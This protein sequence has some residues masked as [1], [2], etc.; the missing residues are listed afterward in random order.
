LYQ[1]TE[2]G[3]N[4]ELVKI[5][6][7]KQQGFLSRT[8]LQSSSVFVL[9]CQTE[10]FIWSG[11]NA[12]KTAK[13]EAMEL[14]IAALKSFNRPPWTPIS[15]MIEGSEN[16]VFQSKFRD[17]NTLLKTTKEEKAANRRKQAKENKTDAFVI[18]IAGLHKGK[19]ESKDVV[20]LIKENVLVYL[21][22]KGGLKELP[23]ESH[24]FFNEKSNYL[25]VFSAT[26]KQNEVGKQVEVKRQYV[27]FW[28]GKSSDKS[29]SNSWRKQVA[30]ELIEK[31]E[32]SSNTSPVT[33]SIIQGQEPGFFFD[34]FPQKFVI[35]REGEDLLSEKQ[36]FHVKSTISTTSVTL[37]VDPSVKSMNAGDAFVLR[38]KDNVYA[39][40]GPFCDSVEK[41][42]A[43]NVSKRI[44]GGRNVVEIVSGSNDS[45]FWSILGGSLK[46]IEQEAKDDVDYSF[47]PRLFHC[48]DASGTFRVEE[49]FNFHQDDLIPEDVMMLDVKNEVFLWIGND[50]RKEEREMSLKLAQQY[51]AFA[52]D[53]RS[54]DC[55][56]IEVPQGNEPWIFTKHFH[57]WVKK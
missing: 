28:Q 53:G 45:E 22:E 30:S 24:G 9:D 10:V 31:L 17:W 16:P 15:S 56:I 49:I 5:D 13:A 19:G 23:F 14:T 20:D 44:A 43:V 46:D 36:L 29:L 48:S 7:D 33:M 39:W 51:I 55:P 52:P 4:V 26:E 1:V 57:G 50:C 21:V 3:E 2:K 34:L 47:V 37:E 38:T 54:Q 6:K 12:S 41:E 18:N 42:T 40:A 35:F 27:A 8:M 32:K 11:K 25:I